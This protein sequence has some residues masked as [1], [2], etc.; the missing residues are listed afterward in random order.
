M[1]L[2][3]ETQAAI[4]RVTST[5]FCFTLTTT[6]TQANTRPPPLKCAPVPAPHCWQTAATLPHPAAAGVTV[7]GPAGQLVWCHQRCCCHHHHQ[8]HHPLL[9]LL[10]QQP[11]SVVVVLLLLLLQLS[12]LWTACVYVVVGQ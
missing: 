12:H 2:R 8:L 4:C 3:A 6:Q 11:Q 1:A 9:R 7:A 5:Q 10:C